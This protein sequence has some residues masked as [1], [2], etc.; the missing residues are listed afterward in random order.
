MPSNQQQIIEQAKFTYSPLG[1]SFE[2]ETKTI[3]DQGK[4]QIDALADFILKEIKPRGTKPNKY[5]DYFLDKLAEIRNSS[6]TDFNNVKYTF[7]DRNNAP[8]DFIGFKGLLH[9]FKGMH[10]GDITLED[11][12]EKDQIKLK[13]DL[14]QIRQRN[15]K[16]RSEEQN[17]VINSVTNLYES[18]EKVVQMFNNYAKNMSRNIYKTKQLTGLKILTPKQ[19]LQRL[20]I[21][22]AQIKAGNN[23]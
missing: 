18:R 7:K 9:I 8:I 21:A 2:K 4:K 3:E 19:M 14:A 23:S 13:S 12:V 5:S 22:L 17:N 11:V 16:N 10:G 6:K 20:P 15:P 1:K